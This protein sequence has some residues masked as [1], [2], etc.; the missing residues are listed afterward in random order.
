M[1]NAEMEDTRKEIERIRADTAIGGCSG[2][3]GG[4]SGEEV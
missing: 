4:C 1:F 3:G 2:G